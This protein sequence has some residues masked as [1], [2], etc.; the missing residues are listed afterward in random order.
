MREVTAVQA[1]RYVLLTT[2]RRDGTPVSTPVWAAPSGG[3]LVGYTRRD[4]GKVKRLRNDPT[5]RV[6]PCDARGRPTGEKMT[7][8]ARLVDGAEYRAVRRTLRARYGL[9]GWIVFAVDR[10]RGRD[11][12][13][14]IA[15]TL[16]PVT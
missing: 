5:V 7:G 2:F 4:A 11:R 15:V 12:T 9:L 16:D 8:R 1:A 10:L 6:A 14:G 13:I 3:G